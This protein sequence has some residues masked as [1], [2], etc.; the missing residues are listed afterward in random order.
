MTVKYGLVKNE[1][2]GWGQDRKL[3]ENSAFRRWGSE[4]GQ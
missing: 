4:P 3:F 2:V 1:D